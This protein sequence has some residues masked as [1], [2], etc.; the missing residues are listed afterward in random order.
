MERMLGFGLWIGCCGPEYFAGS[1]D[2]VLWPGV[3]FCDHDY[4]AWVRKGL[5]RVLGMCIGCWT[6]SSE[7]V[8]IGFS[9]LGVG[10]ECMEPEPSHILYQ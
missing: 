3:G 5:C 1:W 2:R 8:E 6:P 9:M 10:I 4:N 7:F